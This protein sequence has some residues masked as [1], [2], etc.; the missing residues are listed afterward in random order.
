MCI[1]ALK[2]IWNI[3]MVIGFAPII[4]VSLPFV[5]YGGSGL[6]IQMSAVGLILSIYKGKNLSNASNISI[7]S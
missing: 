4:S 6:V 1:F 5:S 7:K 3:L 2:F